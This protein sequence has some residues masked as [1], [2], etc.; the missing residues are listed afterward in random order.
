MILQRLG[1]LVFSVLRTFA[2]GLVGRQ[3]MGF[4][5]HHQ[6]PARRIQQAF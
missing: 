4:V 6:I 5:E 3:V 2:A 1:Q